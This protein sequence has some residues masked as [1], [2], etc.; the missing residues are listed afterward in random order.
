MLGVIWT[1]EQIDA[2]RDADELLKRKKRRPGISDSV[3]WPLA[4][5]LQPSIYDQLPKI[6]GR[7]HGI[8]APRWA[9]KG[10]FV[11][12]FEQSKEDFLSFVNNMVRPKLVRFGKKG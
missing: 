10:E 4:G 9:R 1:R 5:T 12:L 8:D 6:F 3:F 7:K 2:M 11:D